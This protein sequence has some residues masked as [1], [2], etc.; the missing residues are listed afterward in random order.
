MNPKIT[1]HS[2]AGT[3][4]P[5]GGWDSG[6]DLDPNRTFLIGNV[7]SSFPHRILSRS[8][9]K[10]CHMTTVHGNSLSRC[11]THITC[12]CSCR[13]DKDHGDAPRNQMKQNQKKPSQADQ[14]RNVQVCQG[15]KFRS[16][17]G[18]V[19]RLKWQRFLR[20]QLQSLTVLF[21]FYF[22][23]SV[24]L[25][26]A[27]SDLSWA[28]EP[29]DADIREGDSVSIDC[30]VN[31]DGHQTEWRYIED[32]SMLYF[33]DETRVNAPPR[34]DV[35]DTG[36]GYN[37][38]LTG[39]TRDD[40]AEYECRITGWE[41]RRMQLTILG[42]LLY[43]NII[44]SISI[45][46]PLVIMRRLAN[47]IWPYESLDQSCVGTVFEPDFPTNGFKILPVVIKLQVVVD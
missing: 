21:I 19:T 33:L 43:R 22:V 30:Q 17:T 39:A 8:S 41:M 45:R 23:C 38:Q 14:Q 13:L 46:L 27:N 10:C 5:V 25:A 2:A 6:P 18:N 42:K 4:S 47:R 37:L 44:G 1:E 34:F 20:G 36:K 35:L 15:N 26:C 3:S 9:D 7:S 28:V 40:D 32:D 11:A 16:R 29:K 31:S 12:H 24:P